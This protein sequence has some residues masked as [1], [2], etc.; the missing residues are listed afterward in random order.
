MSNRRR[1]VPQLPVAKIDQSLSGYV[2]EHLDAIERLLDAGLKYDTIVS[3]LLNAGLESAAYSAFDA[4]LYRAR[5]RRKLQPGRDS[6]VPQT[7]PIATP[8][9]GALPPVEP[10]RIPPRPDQKGVKLTPTADLKPEDL[11]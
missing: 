9:P 7:D 4:A 2:R 11:Y 6:A 1:A 3:L 5:R 8:Q 10:A